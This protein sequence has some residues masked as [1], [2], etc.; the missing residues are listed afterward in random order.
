MSNAQVSDNW[1]SELS[2]AVLQNL[3]RAGLA[4]TLDDFDSK[5]EWMTYINRVMFDIDD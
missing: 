4:D 2:L 3:D 1:K 5:S